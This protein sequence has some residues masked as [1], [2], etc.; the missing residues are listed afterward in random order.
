MSTPPEPSALPATDPAA[1]AGTLQLLALAA[2]IDAWE[3]SRGTAG[4]DAVLLG[5]ESRT[6]SPVR[7]PRDADTLQSPDVA[8]L[9]PCGEGGGFAGG[10]AIASC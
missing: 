6:S 1:S 7:I 3:R 8:G 5:V 2:A 9:Y 4:G 10:I